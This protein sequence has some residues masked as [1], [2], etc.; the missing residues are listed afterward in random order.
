[1]SVYLIFTEIQQYCIYWLYMCLY[2][3][4]TFI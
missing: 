3:C 1:M 2:I 4:F